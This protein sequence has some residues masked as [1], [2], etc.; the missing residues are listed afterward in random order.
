MRALHVWHQISKAKKTQCRLR[1]FVQ[2]KSDTIYTVGYYLLLKISGGW[3]SLA[4]APVWASKFLVEEAV[5][6]RFLASFLLESVLCECM[7]SLSFFLFYYPS[8]VALSSMAK[9]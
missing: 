7:V 3:G 8:V 5:L 1:V 2:E 9:G 6:D 4:Q